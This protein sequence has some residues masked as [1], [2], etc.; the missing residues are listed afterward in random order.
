MIH[1]KENF[2]AWVYKTKRVRFHCTAQQP[3]WFRISYVPFKWRKPFSFR[4]WLEQFRLEKFSS[5]WS[6]KQYLIIESAKK[7]I[8]FKKSYIAC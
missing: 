5:F 2:V 6:T 7:I 1:L 4:T 8:C 3:I